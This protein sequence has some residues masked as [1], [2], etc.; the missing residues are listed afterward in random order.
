MRVR[1]PPRPVMAFGNIVHSIVGMFVGPDVKLFGGPTGVKVSALGDWHKVIDWWFDKYGRYAVAVK[2]QDAYRR[3]I[4]YEPTSADNVEAVFKRKLE[5]QS[6]SPAQQKAL[7]DHLFWYAVSKA[8]E[9]ELPV[10][11]HTGYYAGENRMPLSRLSHNAASACDLCRAAP[12]TRFVFMH[13]NY[14]YYEELI[15]VAKQYTNAYV[16]M[17]WSWIINPV[18][19]R[20]FL[21][22]YLVTA[23][24]NKIVTFGGDYRYVEQVLGHAAIARRGIAGA[25]DEL[26]EEG[27]LTPDDAIA[28]VEPIMRGNARSIFR[29]EEKE[30]VLKGAPW[31]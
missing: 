29:L 24:A 2:S 31:A 20:D 18:A 7:E 28:L 9:N 12:E 3:D 14:P 30:R 23:P 8:T 16:D 13:V 19:S 1:V 21:K 25:L 11:L 6:V 17:C 26:V 5:G 22:K 27:W 4:D 10:K 15:S